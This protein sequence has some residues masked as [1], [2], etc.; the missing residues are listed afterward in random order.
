[1]QDVDP[2]CSGANCVDLKPL[3]ETTLSLVSRAL[4]QGDMLPLRWEST[5]DNRN[6]ILQR[7]APNWPEWLAL[8]FAVWERGGVLVPLSTLHRPRELAYALDHA[9]VE[10]LV[11]ARAFLRHDYPATLATAAAGVP[12]MKPGG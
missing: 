5:A 9:D 6:E 1:M 12:A 11:A 7:L 2:Y 4:D 10:V 3:D 8:A